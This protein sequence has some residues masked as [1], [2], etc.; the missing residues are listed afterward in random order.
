MPRSMSTLTPGH[1]LGEKNKV[2]QNEKNYMDF[3]NP[4]IWQILK[5]FTGTFHQS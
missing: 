2:A 3:R 1:S 4:K 5:R